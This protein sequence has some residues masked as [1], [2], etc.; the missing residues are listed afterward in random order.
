MLISE[1]LDDEKVV[2]ING[3]YESIFLNFL[4]ILEYTIY[5]KNILKRIWNKAFIDIFEKI[6]MIEG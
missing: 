1:L 6:F 5:T 2:K 3:C 4:D